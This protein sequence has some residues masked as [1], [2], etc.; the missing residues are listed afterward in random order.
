MA[1]PLPDE[2]PPQRTLARPRKKR[3][4]FRCAALMLALVPFIVLEIALVIAGVGTVDLSDDP[5]VGFSEVSPLFELDQ[6][7]NEYVISNRRLK[8]FA[9]DAFPAQKA[10][11]TF[12]IFV[13]GGSTVQ[14]RPYSIETSFPTFARIALETSDL[15]RQWEVINCGGVSYASYRL[16]PILKE[17]LQYEP[18]LIVVCTGHNEFLEDRSYSTIKSLPK[19]IQT[20]S[21]WFLKRRTV[22]LATTMIADGKSS[23][24]STLSADADTILD[25][26]NGIEAFHRDFNHSRAVAMHYESNLNRMVSLTQQANVPLVF[27]LPPSNLSGQ[28]PFKSEPMER[29][30]ADQLDEVKRLRESARDSYRTDLREAIRIWSEIVLA[31]PHSSDNWFEYGQC[32]EIAG[33][34]EE[35]RAAYVKARDL[36][37]C[38]LRMTTPL[39]ESMKKVANERG[40]PLLNLHDHLEKQTTTYILGNQWLVDHVHPSFEGHY[41]IALLLVEW[42]EDTGFVDL[43]ENWKE[44]S[45]DQFTSYF[46]SLDRPY[47]HRGQRALE[48]L[49]NWTRGDRDGPPVRER[50][51]HLFSKEDPSN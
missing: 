49:R 34:H 39:E 6:K 24:S 26:R 43:P 35:A 10:E 18:D 31:D 45:R 19:W 9:P 3:I 15:S 33:Q 23:P 50:F 17:C 14:G 13:L 20:P 46:E 51:P 29:L 21:D 38:P 41:E 12:R 2:N 25:Y 36:D 22:Q 16:V 7:S 11:Q 30:T 44:T 28:L 8:F 1:T 47:F 4:M 27:M 40:I 48:S 37:V 42:M 5:F 32:L